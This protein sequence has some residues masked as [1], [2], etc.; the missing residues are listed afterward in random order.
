[1]FLLACMEVGSGVLRGL[2]R[3]ITSTLVSHAGACLFR[4]VWISTV[5]EHYETLESIYISYPISWALTTIAH[6]T[7]SLLAL[8][9]LIRLRNEH[10][11]LAHD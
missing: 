2:G 8:R 4:I 7:L 1:Y 5:F 11:V 9:K 6:L 3:S 10:P